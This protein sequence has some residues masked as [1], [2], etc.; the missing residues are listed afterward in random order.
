MIWL[1]MAIAK[2][3]TKLVAWTSRQLC[4]LTDHMLFT[5]PGDYIPLYTASESNVLFTRWLI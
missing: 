3:E 2:K 1:G 4:V 5:P